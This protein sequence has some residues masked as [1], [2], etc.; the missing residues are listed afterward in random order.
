MTAHLLILASGVALHVGQEKL[1]MHSA[2]ES[3]EMDSKSLSVFLLGS[4]SNILSYRYM[5]FYYLLKSLQS[6]HFR[7]VPRV[8]V[9]KISNNSGIIFFF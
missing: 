3:I 1:N 2:K 5:H 7:N 6:T 8:S 9:L 4:N